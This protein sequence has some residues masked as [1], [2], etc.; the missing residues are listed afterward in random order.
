[1]AAPASQ[2]PQSKVLLMGR[3]AAGKTSIR[4][5]IFANYLAKETQ[6]LHP[7]NQVEHSNLRFFGSLQLNLWDC[8][9]Q[10][11]FM[12]N[13]FESQREHIFRNVSVLIYILG[14][15]TS[16]NLETAEVG[17]FRSTSCNL[18]QHYHF[19]VCCIT[20]DC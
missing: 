18:M 20:S 19:P 16:C 13:Y 5:I 4:S 3:A 17:V 2:P 14:S 15:S 7:T 8:G 9:G 1:M 12:E 10:D 6:R 11:V